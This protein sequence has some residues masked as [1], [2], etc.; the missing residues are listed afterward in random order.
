MRLVVQDVDDDTPA[1]NPSPSLSNPSSLSPPP[2]LSSSSLSLPASSAQPAAGRA[3]G[4]A[5][6]ETRSVERVGALGRIRRLTRH[7]P[8]AQR[9]LSLLSVSDNQMLTAFLVF[10]NPDRE[11]LYRQFRAEQKAKW[12]PKR[13]ALALFLWFL[14]VVGDLLEEAAQ[15]NRLL[16]LRLGAGLP[17]ALVVAL[18]MLFPGWFRGHVFEDAYPIV[19][20]VVA[21]S[22][23]TGLEAIRGLKVVT[24]P[25]SLLVVIWATHVYLG[26]AFRHLML[27]APV[28]I[29]IPVLWLGL[30]TESLRWE[31]FLTSVVA[32]LLSAWVSGAMTS[33][34]VE[35]AARRQFL[36]IERL[37]ATYP[38]EVD[39]LSMAQRNFTPPLLDSLTLFFQSIHLVTGAQPDTKRAKTRT[40]SLSGFVRRSSLGGAEFIASLA[41]RGSISAASSSAPPAAAPAARRGRGTLAPAPPPAA[42]AVPALDADPPPRRGRGTL[43]PAPLP[44]ALAVPA[45]DADPPPRRGRGTLAPAPLPATLAV[46][47]LDADPPPRS[48][49]RTDSLVGEAFQGAITLKDAAPAVSRQTLSFLDSDMETA[50]GEWLATD[51]RKRVV[52]T[53]A[54]MGVVATLH[55]GSDLTFVRARLETFLL[56]RFAAL[57]PIL[58]I[59]IGLT[60]TPLWGRAR[61]SLAGMQVIVITISYLAMG[62]LVAML[63]LCPSH[64]VDSTAYQLYFTGT[65]RLLMNL[66]PLR[67][68]APATMALSALLLIAFLA[69]ELSRPTRITIATIIG[70]ILWIAVVSVMNGTL[71]RSSERVHRGLYLLD[72]IISMNS[73]SQAALK[74]GNNP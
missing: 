70:N 55:I 20:S 52:T 67:V 53:L 49:G 64:N 21:V 13:L 7:S 1:S 30:G 29:L 50:F 37:Q 10:T 40:N 44:A 28:Q 5:R 4:R 72:Q 62:V 25:T 58:A 60:G 59:G 65:L 68:R 33:F 66:G 19:L 51:Q 36:A 42:L 38:D 6:G 32:V 24:V 74:S 34:G 48:R 2:P 26:V 71:T 16:L 27:M 8:T 41:K 61:G 69:L 63:C 56:L 46:P 9:L 73:V 22:A 45:L 31:K 54:I 14:F 18:R 43:A 35:L 11:G 3:Q 39:L 12:V 23:V 57:I 47:A 17:M 15:R